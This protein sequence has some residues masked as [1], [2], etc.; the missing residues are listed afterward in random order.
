MNGPKSTIFISQPLLYDFRIDFTTIE[1]SRC[2]K[3]NPTV[4]FFTIYFYCIAAQQRWIATSLNFE[5]V[6]NHMFYRFYK[7]TWLISV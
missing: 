2:T 7:E 5:F 4:I 3:K 1:F 6:K